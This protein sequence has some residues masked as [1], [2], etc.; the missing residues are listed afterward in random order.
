MTQLSIDDIETWA[1]QDTSRVAQLRSMVGSRDTPAAP[2]TP[3]E[4]IAALG[5][6]EGLDRDDVVLLAGLFAEGADRQTRLELLRRVTEDATGRYATGE[7]L[8]QRTSER[9]A[10]ARDAMTAYQDLLDDP[11]TDET[12]MQRFIEENLWLLGLDYAYMRPR[13]PLPRGTMDFILERFDGFHD[14]L[15]LKSP[16]DPIVRAPTSTRDTPPSPSEYA[17]SPVLAGALAQAHAYRDIL[18]RHGATVEELY[19]LPDV[20]DPRLIIVIGKADA[21]SRTLLPRAAGVQQVSAPR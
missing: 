10:D 13:Y 20:R 21:P 9:V 19:G 5:T 2:P 8:V 7:V 3:A 18:T 6:L 17:L 4:A 1:S 15:E 14:L 11:A 12:A 16:H